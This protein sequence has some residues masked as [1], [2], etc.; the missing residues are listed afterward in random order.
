MNVPDYQ[1][2]VAEW[3]MELRDAICDLKEL[4]NL[5]NL[6]PQEIPH[7]IENSSFPLRVPRNFIA[8]MEPGNPKDPLL[9][10]VLPSHAE[11]NS[12]QN[13]SND[14]LQEAKSNVAPGLLHKYRDRVLLIPVGSCAINCR[15]CF[16]RHFPYEENIKGRAS[17]NEAL[18]YI[19]KN[20]ELKEVIISGG[21]PLILK[22]T[23]L[24]QLM[25]QIFEVSHIKRIRFHTR[26]PIVLPSRIN[27]DFVTMLSKQQKSIIIVLHCNHPN[28]ID[29][30]VKTAIKK[31]LSINVTV[32]N[33][34]VLLKNI[35]DNTK[36]LIDLSEKLFSCGVLP[37]YLHLLDRV[38]GTA[39]FEVDEKNAK[40]LNWEMMQNLPG[41]LVPKLV[42]EVP[43][44]PAKVP[45]DLSPQL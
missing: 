3:Q 44:A 15:Y 43:G 36:T 30:N 40:Q 2:S 10:Q 35:N 5:L 20:S 12:Y 7:A 16:R 29:D 1:P 6:T 32:L 34:T 41:Y 37:Y 18:K 14:A 45:I 8:K 17:W 27:D 28:E 21:D 13:F 38:Q 33:Q 42:R 24:N 11:N 26:V 4:L 19:E 25:T 23:L 9:L 31:L 39:H 22:D